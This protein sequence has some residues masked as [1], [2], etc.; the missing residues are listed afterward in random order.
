MNNLYTLFETS[1]DRHAPRLA[2]QFRPRYRTLAWTYGELGAHVAHLSRALEAKGI[3]PGDRVLLYAGNSPY[4][5]AAYFGILARGAIV[6]PLNPQGMPDQLDRIVASAEP[7]LLLISTRSPWPA[8]PV[9]WVRIEQAVGDHLDEPLEMPGRDTDLSDLAEIVYTS[10]TTAEPKGVMLTHGNLLANIEATAEI[11]PLQSSDQVISLVPLFHMYGQMTSLL[12]PLKQGSAV[13]YVASPSSRVILDTLA[14][15]PATHLVVVPEFLKT[16]MGRLQERLVSVP[17]FA[18]PLLRNHIRA[19]ISKTL[20]TMACGGAPLDPEVERQ[21]RALGFE[22]VQGYGLTET[23]PVIAGNT[24]T[25]HRLGSAGKPLK[26]IEVKL[27]PEGEILVKG[28]NVMKGYFRDERRTEQVF[29]EGWFKTEDAGR[30]DEDGF[31]YVS[32]RK[33]YMILGS[34]GENVF[35]EDLEA[36]L[37]K[38]PGVKDSAVIGLEERGRTVIH[39]VLLCDQCDGHAIVERANQHLAPHQRIMRWSLW[40]QADFPRSATRKVRKEEVI[41]Q[42]RSQA[43]AKPAGAQGTVTPLIRLLAQITQQDPHSIHES[44][45]IAHDLG[46]DS[47]LRIELVSRI[48]E[49]LNVVIEE[50]QIAAQTTVAELEARLNEQKKRPPRITKYPRWSLSTWANTLRPLAQNLL[51]YPWLSLLCPLRV[52]G[53]EYLKDLKQPVIFM[54][55]HRSFLDAPLAAFAMP[56]P[57]RHKLA[58]AAGTPTLYTRYGWFVPLAELAFNSYPFP[59]Q[60]GENIKPALEY[61][62]RL[63]DNGWN[64][65]VFPEGELNR[66]DQPMQALR[67][68]AGVLAVE[69]QVPVIPMAILGTERILPPDTALPR[70]RGRVEIHFGRPIQLQPE[71]NYAEATRQIEQ[72]IGNLL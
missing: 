40:P 22:V 66:T 58:I 14:H 8:K 2:I 30:F 63:L 15:T 65:L 69:M 21:W 33:K 24:R 13:T 29:Q 7:K 43:E 52:R 35:P 31:L 10:G 27:S 45:K 28:P 49:E 16:M 56:P 37:N 23:S 53:I 18:R 19:Q 38:I 61:T 1:I 60:T 50:N 34:G 70:R 54:P 6:V 32:G 48:E 4:W 41:R 68:G 51:F 3:G 62:G 17:N 5:V 9:P 26:D 72:A 64:V 57:Y 42:L 12:Y 67:G 71:Q 46:L 11:T 20:H 44:T 25:H 47:L 39:A 36:E 59:T 55:N